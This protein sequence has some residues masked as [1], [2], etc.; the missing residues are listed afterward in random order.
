M[1]Y[2]FTPSQMKTLDDNT[3]NCFGI[4]AALLMENAGRGCA[5]YLI[6]NYPEETDGIIIILHGTGNNSGD[7]FVLARW[8]HNYTKS[9]FLL[10]VHNGTMTAES[11]HNFELCKALKIPSYDLNKNLDN[12]DVIENLPGVT[13]IIDAVF[14]TGFKG[15]LPATLKKIFESVDDT[16][17]FKVAID[18]PS[19]LNGANGDGEDAFRANLTLT[20]HS[21]KTGLFLQ[22]GKYKSGKIVTIPIGIPDSYNDAFFTPAILIDNANFKLPERS[23]NAT[24]NDYGRVLAIGGHLGYLGAI[25]MTAKAALRAGAGLVYLVSREE[26]AY[27]YNANPSEYLFVGIPR[28]GKTLTPDLK[29]FSDLF[30]KADSVI[31]GPGLGLDTYA[32]YML[33]FVLRT[34]T[35][36]TVVDADAL[37]LIAKDPA[38]Q[39]YLKKPNILLTPHFGEF[40]ALA[41]I[42]LDQLYEDTPSALE[43][44]VKKTGAKVL[45]KSD[46]TIFCDEKR[47]FINTRGNDGLATGGSGDVLAGIIGSFCGQR[48]ELGE[49]AINASYIMGRTAEEL[50]K[51]RYA[52]SI[53]PTDIIENLF[54]SLNEE[55]MPFPLG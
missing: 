28:V 24:K 7:G 51:K 20:L 5:D 54:I 40:C 41:N 6:N 25:S 29:L 27:F 34:S 53:L 42:T 33:E 47:M 55:P 50:A 13:M 12:L 37:R 39:Q 38:L 3:I 18:I 10:K 22:Y 8:L 23:F 14:G 44:F 17:A 49:A 48:M 11:K 31:I 26:N 32:N 52:P 4:P 2:V 9:V 36:P 35:V 15:K 21:F 1:A 19:G 45:L 43:N 16:P 30:K 46:T